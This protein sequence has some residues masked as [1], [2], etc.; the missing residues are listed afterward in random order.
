MVRGEQDAPSQITVEVGD[1]ARTEGFV[2]RWLVEPD[3][4]DTRTAEEGHDAGAYWGV[5]LTRRGRIAVYTAH[6]NERWPGQLVDYD[7][8]ENAGKDRSTP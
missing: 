5:A 2:G 7:N 3:S 8:I 6:C 1:P 4:D